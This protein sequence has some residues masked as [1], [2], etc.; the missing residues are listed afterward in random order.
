[1]KFLSNIEA[2]YAAGLYEGEGSLSSQGRDEEG[3]R[4]YT[5][6]KVAMTDPDVIV[7]LHFLLAVG[8]VCR[9]NPKTAKKVGHKNKVQV[10]IPQCELGPVLAQ[11]YP[12]LG[13][14]RARDVRDAL[15]DAVELKG[16]DRPMFVE[17]DERRPAA[18]RGDLAVIASGIVPV[19]PLL[20]E[21]LKDGGT[22]D[23]RDVI[24]DTELIA[25]YAELA[26]GLDIPADLP[27]E[28]I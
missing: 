3:R 20:W 4:T 26:S 11:I 15:A 23:W 25:L 21:C 14:R 17:T 1:M 12:W 7:S 2:A 22:A 27:L 10:S 18:R 24:G 8:T 9:W 5:R 19:V 6:G 28:A 13:D 16:H